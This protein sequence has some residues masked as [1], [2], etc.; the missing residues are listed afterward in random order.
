MTDATQ[1]KVRATR[2]GTIYTAPGD[3]GRIVRDLVMGEKFRATKER[4][5]RW[6]KLSTRDGEHVG[7][8]KAKRLSPHPETK[9]RILSDHWG[10]VD[11]KDVR[12]PGHA[13]RNRTRELNAVA[14][15]NASKAADYNDANTTPVVIGNSTKAIATEGHLVASEIVGALNELAETIEKKEDAKLPEPSR[16]RFAFFDRFMT[17][18]ERNHTSGATD[19]SVNVSTS[20]YR[21]AS[22]LVRWSVAGATLA[23]VAHGAIGFLG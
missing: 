19:Q 7:Y 14:L 15:I 11:P 23:Y 16:S 4:E 21:F 17:M 2:Q 12:R 3:E 9:H 22:T 6:A 5:G 8:T 20:R 13:L 1:L 10:Y 18:R